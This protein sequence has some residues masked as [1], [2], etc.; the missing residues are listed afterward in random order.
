[1]GRFALEGPQEGP[2]TAGRLP[3]MGY[4]VL[5]VEDEA[6]IMMLLEDMLAE[7]G[8]IVAGVAGSVSEA[9]SQI[10]HTEIDAAILDVNL[11]GEKIF[12]VADVLAARGTPFVFS[13][14]YGPADLKERYP[15]SPILHKPYEPDALAEVLRSFA[16]RPIH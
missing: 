15:H 16:N 5:I 12:P 14:A 1:M 9:M 4:Q 8:C 3:L 13:T 2:I 11:A 6:M 10:S 7:F